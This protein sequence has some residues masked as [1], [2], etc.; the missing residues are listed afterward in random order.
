[1]K[2]FQLV[3]LKSPGTVN[4]PKYGTIDLEKI[5]DTL[6][7]KLFNE[8]IPFILPVPRQEPPKRFVPTKKHNKKHKRTYN[9]KNA[10]SADGD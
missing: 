5:D 1:M 9:F 10:E 7:E 3:G 2:N 4:L 6:A 8:G